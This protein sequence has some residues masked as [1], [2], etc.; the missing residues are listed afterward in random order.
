MCYKITIRIKQYA[1]KQIEEWLLCS[2]WDRRFAYS[3]F[4]QRI[5]LAVQR[6]YI[7]HTENRWCRERGVASSVVQWVVGSILI[8]GP[9]EL[10]LS[11][12]PVL[13]DWC[14][15][16]RGMCYPVCGIVH[17]KEPLLL[18]GKSI[19]CDG[20]GFPLSL[21]EWFLTICPTPYN[22]K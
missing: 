18:F 3:L 22:H 4:V 8:G 10:F 7:P 21:S 12:Q 17:I 20:C 5:F 1:T 19:P 11:F 14:N 9:T 6:W 13:H 15:K 16:G 2:K